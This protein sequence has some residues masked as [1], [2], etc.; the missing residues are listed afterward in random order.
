MIKP[1]RLQ[2]THC[3]HTPRLSSSRHDDVAALGR[4]SSIYPFYPRGY[5]NACPLH[6]PRSFIWNVAFR[7]CCCRRE[8]CNRDRIL[9]CVG[10]GSYAQSCRSGHGPGGVIACTLWRIGRPSRSRLQLPP[11]LR[12][13]R[14]S[15]GLWG[16]AS[17]ACAFAPVGATNTTF[18]CRCRCRSDL[19]CCK[20]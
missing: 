7:L 12:N 4:T 2:T 11:S 19:C 18:D 6:N 17:T 20:L 8:R 5:L 1:A 13:V 10:D 3:G 9:V 15:C 14:D 16:S